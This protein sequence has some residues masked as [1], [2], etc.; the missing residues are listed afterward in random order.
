[1][2][3]SG[4]GQGG[5]LVEVG[6]TAGIPG[7]MG[8]SAGQAGGSGDHPPR[9]S[10]GYV[11]D[12]TEC[13]PASCVRFVDWQSLAPD[14]DG[15]S[16][17]TAFTEVSAGID[18]ATSAVGSACPKG[19]HVWVA[20]GTYYVYGT[21]SGTPADTI[22][23][24]SHVAVFGGFSGQELDLDDR[25]W[26]SNV[27]VL[28][29][30]ASAGSTEQ[31][32]HVLT[33]Y[34][35]AGCGEGG[36][37]LDGFTVTG[38][39]A[40]GTSGLDGHGG[41]LRLEQG[42]LAIDHC[43]FAG[44]AAG[45]PS[46]SALG[47]G[48][49]IYGYLGGISI[50]DSHFVRNTSPRGSGAVHIANAALEVR[51][52]LFQSNG[53]STYQDTVSVTD[54]VFENT[55]GLTGPALSIFR[56]E[57]VAVVEGC[58]FLGDLS[59][60][61][62]NTLSVGTST[63]VIRD[64]LFYRNIGCLGTAV[65]A[66]GGAEV[67]IERSRFIENRGVSGGAISS[68]T[69]STVEIRN[70]LF[71][72][73]EV[74]VDPASTFGPSGSAIANRANVRVVNSTFYRNT[75]QSAGVA[76]ISNVDASATTEV[77]NS[78]LWANTPMN[79]DD[80]VGTSFV[81]QYSTFDG[82]WEGSG[83]HTITE[84]PRFRNTDE[85]AAP[86]DLRLTACSPSV[87][88]GA[89]DVAPV[90]DIEG[91]LRVG[92][93]DHGA[94]EFD[95]EGAC[96]DGVGCTRDTAVCDEDTGVVLCLSVPVTACANDDGCCPAGC[97]T[98]SDADCSDRCGNG[99]V[100]PQETCDGDCP[101]QCSDGN[102]CTIDL[103]S[104]SSGNCS[105]ACTYNLIHECVDGDGCCPA[106]CTTAA[107]DDCSTTCGNGTIDDGETCDGDCPVTCDDA[108]SCT[109][110]WLTGNPDLCSAACIHQRRFEPN[111]SDGCCP[112]GYVNYQDRDCPAVCDNGIVEDGETCEGDCIESCTP[113]GDACTL[114]VFTGTP[115]TCDA[116]CQYVDVT[117]CQDGDGCCPG[118][119]VAGLD[120]D[121]TVECYEDADCA[122]AGMLCIES[123]CVA[124]DTREHCGPAC[125]VCDLNAH[126]APVEG[127]N[128]CECNEGAPGDGVSCESCIRY[129]DLDSTAVD[130]VGETWGTAFRS[131]NE[132]VAAAA[133]VTA[134][135]R[136]AGHAEVWVAAGTYF[137][138]RTSTAN[139]INLANGVAIYGGF[140]GNEASRE[141][142][143]WDL[144]PTVLD[145]CRSAES[146]GLSDRVLHVVTTGNYAVIDG[147]T[148]THGYAYNR[149]VTNGACGGGVYAAGPVTLRNC[150]VNNN[151]AGVDDGS[152][153]YCG[154]GGLHTRAGAT[155]ENCTFEYNGASA[156]GGGAMRL[157]YGTNRVEGCVFRNNWAT[158]YGGGA[159]TSM[160]GTTTVVD[161]HFEENRAT[162]DMPD[163]PNGVGGAI[164]VESG[165][166]N[167]S[168]SLFFGNYAYYAGDAI[169]VGD[170]YAGGS[171]GTLNVVNSTFDGNS[172]GMRE[173]SSVTIANS[174]LW[175]AA[176][177]HN[178]VTYSNTEDGYPGE[179]N[180]SAE[181]RFVDPANGDYRLEPCS[182]GIDR[183]NDTVA[184]ALDILGNARVDDTGVPN[185]DGANPEAD[186]CDWISDMG[187]YEY[188]GAP[189]ED[190]P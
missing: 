94:Y 144:N 31:V 158:Y 85:A 78:I 133:L 37:R 95:P 96:D 24:Q 142:R 43:R 55:E 156:L 35:T 124:C 125:T 101:T 175:G 139:T 70:S 7:E 84:D 171:T 150:R 87:D 99:A 128:T 75:S 67:T 168:G 135:D 122:P 45:N 16:W 98:A 97:G 26:E 160:S 121:C 9:C 68:Q 82:V 145:G 190:C 100:D 6:G 25:D 178:F 15:L 14:P 21:G 132:G 126:C 152:S 170:R 130:P 29:G 61:R 104:G 164:R 86:L 58:S 34:G 5:A 166:V 188:V 155:I 8:G 51:D 105:A 118:R 131:V 151:Y 65:D 180:I 102:A 136:C 163:S 89:S 44:N 32:Y 183:G 18:A 119:C 162:Y 161:S 167:V 38:G 71:V 106:G 189:S 112:E 149:S 186:D 3:N 42:V 36:A 91:H 4:G 64:S 177:Q 110:D 50:T 154:G 187:A 159:M 76:V 59:P 19:A 147:F 134:D 47:D 57:G 181:P 120:D 2:Q 176:Y 17:E 40:A 53:L 114:D 141:E 146:C 66:R 123:L 169:Q 109:M 33:C 54:T 80:S 111:D 148:I 117:E 74:N 39:N 83:S 48:P 165:T 185:C 23:L 52:S 127:V 22:A 137:V 73:N 90:T 46:N 115:E 49:A 174:I 172:I 184:P 116:L 1:G 77:Q 88:A 56:C 62:T 153:H 107:D 113:D 20:A 63:A 108:D 72:D 157:L 10:V 129:V 12:G 143:D 11:W 30:H 13:Y 173:S 182:P 41:G 103:L 28:D 138:Y 27:T 81:V 79:F 93:P 60:N 92:P 69:A 140:Q 179:G